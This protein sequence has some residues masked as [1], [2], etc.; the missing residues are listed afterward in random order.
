MDNSDLL[1][2]IKE[3][4]IYDVF[5]IA[6]MWEAMMIETGL[7]RAGE[8]L[9]KEQ[10][11]METIVNIKNG[12]HKI[13]ISEGGFISGNLAQIDKINKLSGV[14]SHIYIKP[15][16]R[17]THLTEELIDSL[18]NFFIAN[19]AQDEQFITVYDDKLIRYWNKRGFKPEK[20]IFRREV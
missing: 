18:H 19:E 15:E 5:K 12:E 1:S 8:T 17:G 6:D 9:N 16:Y 20:I 2:M 13:C 10:F 7:V 11:I 4:T 3:A 14:Y